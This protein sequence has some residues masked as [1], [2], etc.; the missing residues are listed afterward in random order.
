MSTGSDKIL[1]IIANCKC[2]CSFVVNDHKEVCQTTAEAIENLESCGFS[3]PDDIKCGMIERDC[4]VGIQMYPDTPVGFIMILHY[5]FALAVD[6]A[7]DALV[8][9]FGGELPN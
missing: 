3:I 4:I 9:D 7:Y 2:S 1:K 8:R 6:E 5:D